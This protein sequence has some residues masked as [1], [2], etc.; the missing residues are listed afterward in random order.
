MKGAFDDSV[1]RRR[2]LSDLRKVLG[3]VEEEFVEGG[4]YYEAYE[5]IEGVMY[6][7]E[8]L[9]GKPDMLRLLCYSRHRRL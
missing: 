6:P 2:E 5:P 8:A 7:N 1:E 4:F 9:N 3:L